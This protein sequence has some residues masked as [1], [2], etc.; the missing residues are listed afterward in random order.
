LTPNS[1][2]TGAPPQTPLRELTTLPFP[3]PCR[4]IQGVLLLNGGRGNKGKRKTEE[5]KGEKKRKGKM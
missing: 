5:K 2:S 3:R 4:W 1:I